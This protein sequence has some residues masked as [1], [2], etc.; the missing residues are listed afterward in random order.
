MDLDP[1]EYM[2]TALHSNQK[3]TTGPVTSDI[4]FILRPAN[5]VSRTSNR[6]VPPQLAPVQRGMMD[7]HQ[8]LGSPDIT[9]E[10]RRPS[11]LDILMD[12]PRSVD[13]RRPSL[14]TN[15]SNEERRP[16]N[17]TSISSRKS[18]LTPPH[19]LSVDA[20]YRPASPSSLAVP[21]PNGIRRTSVMS[22]NNLT[23]SG[24]DPEWLDANGNTPSNMMA[25]SNSLQPT[26]THELEQQQQ[27]QGSQARKNSGFKAQLKRLVGWGSKSKK[28]ATVPAPQQ[29]DQQPHQLNPGHPHQFGSQSYIHQN[30]SSVSMQSPEA[31]Y[32]PTPSQISVVSAPAT[33]LTPSPSSP[34]KQGRAMSVP[35][36][37]NQPMTSQ[38]HQAQ[39]PLSSPI[40]ASPLAVLEP[41]QP[42]ERA[43]SV[44]SL[45]SEDTTDDEDE[46]IPNV[47][48]SDDS[49]DE[50]E[51]E[52]E[53]QH[54]EKTQ[55]AQI[56][57]CSTHTTP[58]GHPQEL[59]AAAPGTAPPS[60]L[61]DIQAQYA[62]WM[63]SQPPEQP[64]PPA[65]AKP[66]PVVSTPSTAGAPVTQES[67]ISASPSSSSTASSSHQSAAT[68]SSTSCTSTNKTEQSAPARDQEQVQPTS[69]STQLQQPMSS[70]AQAQQPPQPSQRSSLQVAHGVDSDLLLLVTCGVDY[71]KSRETGK[72]E[73]EGGYE[74]HP[75]NRPEGS[76]AVRKRQEEEAAK[77]KAEAKAAAALEAEEATNNPST[78][79]ITGKEIDE[80]DNNSSS[81]H[82]PQEASQASQEAPQEENGQVPLMSPISTP[83]TPAPITP[84]KI[85]PVPGPIAP[86]DQALQDDEFQ[87]I[88]ASHIVF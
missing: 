40:T 28:A 69:T 11:I 43:E 76:F 27:Q 20:Q 31:Y 64:T 83:S 77:A 2:A 45:S 55:P 72:W 67:E 60:E 12:S 54:S 74:F 8:Q 49:S 68:T 87:R 17:P 53:E 62:M 24:S 30:T 10:S 42:P 6:P 9:N 61:N 86:K 37:R 88:V 51:D 84:T 22:A 26:P 38:D 4:L 1:R 57:E 52:E 66:V 70:A 13:S 78:K 14:M 47:D 39:E 21:G 15:G 16:S 44:T 29:S 3:H 34:H 59:S 7:N 33:P 48:I 46:D 18:S 58:Q 81:S 32:D 56:Q 65:A 80:A 5:T 50:E 19:P 25:R 79:D 23:H 35:T 85:Q 36:I 82:D 71:L 63:D 73:D 75:W 41:F